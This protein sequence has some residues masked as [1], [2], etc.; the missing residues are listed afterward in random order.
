MKIKS[1]WTY[2]K[3]DWINNRFVNRTISEVYKKTLK[4]ELHHSLH[5]DDRKKLVKFIGGPTGY[6]SYYLKDLLKHN[7]DVLCICAGTVNKWARCWVKWDELEKILKEF[8]L[9]TI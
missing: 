6:E 5:I 4:V 8:D 7:S 3:A 9:K 2:E 1:Y